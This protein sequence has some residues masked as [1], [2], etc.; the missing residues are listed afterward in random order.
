MPRIILM[1][2]PGSG[3][4]TVGKVLAKKTELPLIDTDQK[5]EERT[6]RKIPDIFLESGEDEFRKLE[7][8]EV[9]S[10][11]KSDESI[12]SLGGGSILDEQ[13]QTVLA[14][15]PCVVFLDVSISNAAPRVGLNKERPLLV[16]APRQQWLSLMQARRPIYERLATL[17]CSTDNK[18]PAEVAEEILAKVI[19]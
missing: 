17:T 15:M 9:F 10:A 6:G 3:K 13:V 1:G 12:V 7:R 2:P 5:I 4:T 11:L 8:E 19:L 14:T 18:K 16:G